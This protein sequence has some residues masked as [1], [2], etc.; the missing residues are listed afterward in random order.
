MFKTYTVE[1]TPGWACLISTLKGRLFGAM[2]HRL[3]SITGQSTSQTTFVMKIAS[4]PLGLF[5]ITSTNGMM[6]IVQTATGSLA[7]KITTSAKGF[8]R[9]VQ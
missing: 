1:N 3:T 9:T 7:K 6:S 2:E 5:E 8:H 4:T